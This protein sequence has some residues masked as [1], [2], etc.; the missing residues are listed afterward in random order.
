[1]VEQLEQIRQRPN[2]N[3]LAEEVKNI[4]IWGQNV[5]D[6][7]KRGKQEIAHQIERAI[8]ETETRRKF[9]TNTYKFKHTNVFN[10]NRTGELGP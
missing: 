2:G 3:Q 8:V 10:G 9:S 5:R 6:R 7:N 4:M 1:M